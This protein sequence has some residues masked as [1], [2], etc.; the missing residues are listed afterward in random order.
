MK[1]IT[2]VILSAL[3]AFS[4][5]AGMAFSVS[6]E[7]YAVGDIN[8]DGKTDAADAAEI[9]MLCAKAGAEGFGSLS[10]A[11]RSRADYNQDGTV[12]AS[13]AGEILV[14]AAESGAGGNQTEESFNELLLNVIGQIPDGGGYYTGRAAKAELTQNAWEGMDKAVVIEENSVT[15]DMNEA[16]PS[17]CS[18]ATYMALLKTL[19]VWDT[20]QVISVEAWKNLKPYTVQGRAWAIQDDGVG[21]WGRANANGPGFA[22]LAAQFGAGE[23]TYIA[24]KNSYASEEDYFAA[25][26]QVKPGDFVK[27]F[28]NKY[29]GDNGS[30]SESGHMV[31]FLGFTESTDADGNRTGT[32]R[33]WSSNGSGYQPD[34]GYGISETKISSVYRAVSTRI[35]HPESFADAE[36]IMPDNKDAWLYSLN[37]S[38]LATE[39]ELLQAISGVSSAAVS[40]K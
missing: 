19:S 32:V 36:K 20:E 34:R 14:F 11:Q 28:W 13:D 10:D 8:E 23:N 2:A 26:K 39:K 35:T 16:R 38:H 21:C 29:I 24:P 25:W 6:A 3:L 4:G 12:D 17:F 7:E 31:I 37:G 30:N 1:K 9:L 5:C 15:I 33:Y 22:V 40:E 27:L 18:S